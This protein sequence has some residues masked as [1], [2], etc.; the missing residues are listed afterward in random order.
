MKKLT[1]KIFDHQPPEIDWAG[2]DAFGLLSFGKAEYPRYNKTSERWTGFKL[3]AS[4]VQNS[5]FKACTSIRR[6]SNENNKIQ[7]RR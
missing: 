1:Q 3:L 2:V 4:T 5:G 7:K 6:R